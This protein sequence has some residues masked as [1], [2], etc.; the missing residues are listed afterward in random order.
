MGVHLDTWLSMEVIFNTCY[1]CGLDFKVWACTRLSFHDS[2]YEHPVLIC[3][4]CVN[5]VCMGGN[6]ELTTT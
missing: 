5:I 1:V 2:K 6:A 4:G 3:A